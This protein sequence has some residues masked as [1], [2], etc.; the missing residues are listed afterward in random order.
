MSILYPVFTDSAK[1]YFG[2]EHFPIN[3]LLHKWTS[4]FGDA[5]INQTNGP[6][7]DPCIELGS[8][9][10][11]AK[12]MD[13][14]ASWI[15]GW[16][17]K[18]K[19]NSADLPDHL[20]YDISAIG[21]PGLA[22]GTFASLHINHDGTITGSAGA[23]GSVFNTGDAAFTMHVNVWYYLELKIE[24]SGGSVTLTFRVDGV[25]RGSG[26]GSHG[27]TTSNLVINASKANF[28]KIYSPQVTG[29]SYMKDPVLINLENGKITDFLGD[30]EI[31]CL[32]TNGDIT[33][34]WNASGSPAYTSVNSTVP[35]TSDTPGI[36]TDTEDQLESFDFQDI[37]SFVGTVPFAQMVVCARKDDEGSNSIKL[38][39]GASGGDAQSQEFY[40]DDTFNFYIW[41]MLPGDAGWTD[42]ASFNAQQFGAR[43]IKVGA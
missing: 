30:V 14:S 21:K 40:L 8:S 35:P 26:S 2:Q 1:H 33:T 16:R 41:P 43:S 7:G 42:A 31:L 23:G 34:E 15:C 12:T 17:L 22:G 24:L 18:M 28:H 39:A 37:P 4:Q 36:N 19:S 29:T 10:W 11:V 20:L 5:S 6:K 13:Y 9:G 32:Y 3:D 25:E 27:V 38:T